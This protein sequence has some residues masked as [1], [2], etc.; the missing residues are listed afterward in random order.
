[1][2]PVQNRTTAT[3]RLARIAL[4]ACTLSLCAVTG[5]GVGPHP[6]PA[7]PCDQTCQDGAA[8]LGL[9]SAMKAVYNFTVAAKH[10]GPQDATT[11]CVS[12]DGSHG[13]SV[14]LFGDAT[15]NAVQGASI[16][17][18]SYDLKNC[19]YSAPPDPTADQNFSLTLTGLVTEQGTLSVQPTAT[20]AL[21]IESDSL[22]VSGTVYDPPLDYA[23][24][25]C[26]LSVIQNG[27]AVSGAFCGRSAGF[28]F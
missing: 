14:H 25:G 11:P 13:G 7:P 15:V 5:C 9:R 22:T 4:A 26:A 27:N 24:S 12:F 20:T 2:S 19:L 23:A 8:L 3:L 28:S 17:S 16:V 6:A 1:M 21:L 10:V 18:L